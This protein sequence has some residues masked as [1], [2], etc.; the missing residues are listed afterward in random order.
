MSEAVTTLIVENLI[1]GVNGS[2]APKFWRAREKCI[3]R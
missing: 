1:N 2:Y 3:V